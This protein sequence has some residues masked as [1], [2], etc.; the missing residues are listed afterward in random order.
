[1]KFCWHP[2]FFQFPM[3]QLSNL[4]YIEYGALFFPFLLNG[5]IILPDNPR[6]LWTLFLNKAKKNGTFWPRSV[7]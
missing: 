1:M 6:P 2:H 3:I 7:F 5:E 4:N